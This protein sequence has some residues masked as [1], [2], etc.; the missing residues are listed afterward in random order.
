MTQQSLQWRQIKNFSLAISTELV[1]KLTGN[2]LL[3]YF[4]CKKHLELLGLLHKAYKVHTSI[5][6]KEKGFL[7]GIS[8][9]QAAIQNQSLHVSLLAI[10]FWFDCCRTYLIDIS[11]PEIV[12]R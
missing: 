10:I 5:L 3:K 8:E 7:F 2:P 12:F 11:F 1:S 9:K 4:L 6:E